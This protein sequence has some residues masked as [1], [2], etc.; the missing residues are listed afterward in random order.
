MEINAVTASNTLSRRK[1][2]KVMA[3][4][5]ALSGLGYWAN[6]TVKQAPSV[7]RTDLLMGMVVNLTL[8][9]D[10]SAQ[11]EAAADATLAEMRRLADLFTR[12]DPASPVS[13][14]N[15]GDIIGYP[16]PELR[17]LLKDAQTLHTVSNGAFDVTVKPLLDLYQSTET[18]DGSLPSQAA[19]ER[20]LDRVGAQNLRITGDEICFTQASMGLTL[21]GIAK[22]AV[23]DGGVG[24]LNA[25]GFPNVLVEA[26]GD[27]LASGSHSAQRPWKIALRAPRADQAM[28]SLYVE[29]R[30]VATSG[31]YLQAFASDY[32]A[33]H[34]IDPRRGISPA[35]LASA[36]VIA[37][38]A[39]LADSL[40]TAIMVAGSEAGVA[41]LAHYPGC[42]AC[43]IDKQFRPILSPGMADYLV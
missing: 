20:A 9:G 3:V 25:H 31:D 13:Q 30:A 15:K 8:M 40:A 5:G 19:V 11:A 28:P 39:A 43:L 14:L 35:E 21:D 29:N 37:P 34:I 33:H 7:H 17:T 32:S 36:T 41:L 6:R 4:G 18:R 26:G 16:S 27:L 38:T 42:E 12:F 2:L 24:T 22:G 1:F 10:E 23:I